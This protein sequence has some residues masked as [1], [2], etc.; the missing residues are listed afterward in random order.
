M[1]KP[2][3]PMFDKSTKKALGVT[4]VL[5]ALAASFLIFCP[6]KANAE[7]I[8]AGPVKVIS[9]PSAVKAPAAKPSRMKIVTAKTDVPT[10]AVKSPHIK[11]LVKERTLNVLKHGANGVIVFE[12][13]EAV[14]D[15]VA[16]FDNNGCVVVID[17]LNTLRHKVFVATLKRTECA[18]I[19]VTDQLVVSTDQVASQ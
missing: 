12:P 14:D 2:K 7:V 8:K 5:V 4:A 18:I 11:P 15:I 13:A 10:D 1:T 17:D 3:V 9:P 16:F 19:T 6:V